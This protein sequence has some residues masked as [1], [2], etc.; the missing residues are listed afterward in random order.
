MMELPKRYDPLEEEPRIQEFW[1]KEKVYKF[2]P[3]S[4]KKIFSIDTP[5]PTVS[6]KM[7]IGHAFSFSQ[8]DFVARYKRMR[9]FNLFYPFGTDDNGLATIRL[10]ESEK[11]VKGTM[12]S[13]EEFIRLTMEVLDEVRPKYISDWK[14]IGTSADF[15][16]YYSTIN[17]HC[18][19][20]SQRSFIDQYKDGRVYRK[21]APT[22]WCPDCQTAIAQVEMEDDEQDSFFNDIIFRIQETGKDGNKEEKDLIIATTRPEL[23]PACVAIFAHPDDERYK[24]MI[25]KKAKVPLFNHEVP[26]LADEKA[27]PEK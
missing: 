27:D 13:R 1:E 18:R 9:G 23:L 17:E 8:A 10:V 24:D 2:D 14:R 20:I 6:G 22:L 3:K 11:K 21:E 19:K 5:P 12:M 15:D 4:D 7:H 26:I 25:G 16:I